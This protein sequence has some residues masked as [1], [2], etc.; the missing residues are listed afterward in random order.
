MR[1]LTPYAKAYAAAAIG[2]CGAVATGYADGIMATGEWWSAA[3]A[4]LASAGVVWGI[5]NTTPP[6]RGRGGRVRT[7]RPGV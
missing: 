3:A 1:H 7:N 6:S 2:F 5:P 4:A